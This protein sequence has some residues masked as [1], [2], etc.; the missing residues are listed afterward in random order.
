MPKRTPKTEVPTAG[1]TVTPINEKPKRAKQGELAGIEAPN[2]PELDVLMEEHATL[3]ESIGSARQ[4]MGELNTQMLQEATK[5]GCTTYRHPT[6]VPALTLTVTEGTTKVK[7]KK[8]KH[9]DDGN[10][11]TE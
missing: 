9:D 7:V 11:A 6:A 2:H 5:L 8:A 4:R 1:A 3:A 10:E